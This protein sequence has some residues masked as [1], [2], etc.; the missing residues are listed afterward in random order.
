M[1]NKFKLPRTARWLFERFLPPEE[2]DHV[3]RGLGEVFENLCATTGRSQARLWFWSQLSRSVP[4]LIKYAVGGGLIMLKNYFRIALRNFKRYKGYTFINLAGLAFGMTSCLLILLYIHSELSYDRYHEHADSICRV[5]TFLDLGNREL[6]IAT[7]NHPIGLTLE[8]DYPEVLASVK[9]RPYLGRIQAV[10]GDKQFMEDDIFLAE[11]SIFEVFTFPLTS[12][13]PQTAL[14]SPYTLVITETT[15]ERYFGDSEPLGKVIRL[16]DRWDF[17][18]T[19][20]MKDVPENSHFTFDMLCSFETLYEDIPQQ[21]E[22]WMGDIDNY[23]YILLQ[24]D[25][26]PQELESKLPPLIEKNVGTL[27]KRLGGRFELSLQPLTDIRLYSDLLGE[28][29]TTGNIRYIYIFSIC[30]FFILIIACFNFMNLSTARSTKRAKEIAMRKVLGSYRKQ[31]VKQFL[32]ESLF[33]SFL[34]LIL[35]LALVKFSLPIFRS[36]S[37]TA[38][39]IHLTD[40]SW[41][42]P[43]CIGFMLLVGLMAGSYPALFLSAFRPAQVL[44]G[45]LGSK[46]KHSQ[47][48]NILVV[49]QFT[50][51]IILMIGT[52]VIASQL[53]YMKKRNLGFNKEH[54][55]VLPIGDNSDAQSLASIKEE[56]R[57]HPGVLFVSAASNVPGYGARHNAFLP[58]GFQVDESLMFGS[59]SIDHEFLPTL[60]IEIAAGRNFAQEFRTDESTSVL[61]NQTAAKRI[62]WSDE[63]AVGKTIREL[64]GRRIKKTIIGVVRDFHITSLHQEIESIILE[65]TPSRFGFFSIRLDAENISQ[66]MGFLE[67]TWNRLFPST[68]F[69]YFF[70]DDSFDSQYRAEE[71]LTSLFSYF[72]LFAILI[73]CLGLFG[74][75]SFT[76][77]QKTKEVG[78]RKV[79]GATISGICLLFSR[80]FLKWILLA[81]I[82]AWPIAYYAMNQWLQGFAYRTNLG[83]GIFALSTG[84]A[85]L[86]AIVT[87]SFQSIKAALANPVDSLRYE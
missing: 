52:F 73:A 30:A 56:L 77:E 48:R 18:V 34:A 57:R 37:G 46:V 86:I 50:I 3:L 59:V 83:I 12:G 29:S 19:G 22:R 71:R 4:G 5:T 21:R 43:G 62:G 9:L 20:V 79:M 14:A 6:D 28:L 54:V 44:K 32:V 66:T 23:T 72:T 38:M 49:I 63:N 60:G 27:M 8:R 35:A 85:L 81:N 2:K 47:F 11:T 74:L 84:L 64:D 65:N 82:L 26:D 67:K 10:S 17:T 40:I 75:T 36:Y 31:L 53:K 68:S 42:I 41:L 1:N 16:D 70:L 80:E 39:N 15:A 51:S 78:I 69:D 33:Y 45:A 13:D 87:V 55:A 24:E 76:V 7:S 58:E 61:I 25:F